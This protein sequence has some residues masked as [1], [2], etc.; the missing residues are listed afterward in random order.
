MPCLFKTS[1]SPAAHSPR[2]YLYRRAKGA[3]RFRP[4]DLVVVKRQKVDAEY[5]TV[6]ATGV[7]RIRHGIQS[8]FTSLAEWVREKT[9]FDL[10]SSIDFFKNYL[11]GR[12]FRRWHKVRGISKGWEGGVVQ[13]AIKRR[14]DLD[15]SHFVASPPPPPQGVRQQNLNRMKIVIV[16]GQAHL[17]NA[18]LIPSS[19]PSPPPIHRVYARRT[20]TA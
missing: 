8:E 15:L 3:V 2:T 7:M 6:S 9:L 14:E 17:L 4:Y 11:T 16:P 13:A 5:F 20:S 12:S 18:Y 19:L 10:I 1:A